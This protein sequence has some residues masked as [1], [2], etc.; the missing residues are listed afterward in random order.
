MRGVSQ[1]AL[2]KTALNRGERTTPMKTST[3]SSRTSGQETKYRRLVEDSAKH[4]TELALG[5]TDA[6]SDGWQ[7]VLENGDE[8]RDAI[9][10]VVVAKTQELSVRQRGG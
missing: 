7:R 1:Q 5:K 3:P 8:L 4:A 6:D 9:A 10:E 2:W